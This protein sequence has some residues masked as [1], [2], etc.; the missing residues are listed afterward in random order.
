MVLCCSGAKRGGG[1]AD[2]EGWFFLLLKG[3]EQQQN[4]QVHERKKRKRTRQFA[5]RSHGS[6]GGSA[7]LVQPQR[8]TEP[9]SKIHLFHLGA[10]DKGVIH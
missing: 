8:L 4:K 6:A 2:Q 3:S 9:A 5:W 1:G 10:F 7:R